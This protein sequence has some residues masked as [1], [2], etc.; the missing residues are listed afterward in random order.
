VIVHLRKCISII[1]KVF[2]LKKTCF[3]QTFET[4]REF[5]LK[6]F[7]ELEFFENEPFSPSF[8]CIAGCNFNILE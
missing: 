4:I 3:E 2:F 1:T 7:S 5:Q 6:L 8:K